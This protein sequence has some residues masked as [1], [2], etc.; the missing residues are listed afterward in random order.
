M[1]AKNL[2]LQTV[3][4][5]IKDSL[6]WADNYKDTRYYDYIDGVITMTYNLLEKIEG[7]EKVKEEE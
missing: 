5:T 6:E 3:Y 1:V 4:E 2:I 7:T